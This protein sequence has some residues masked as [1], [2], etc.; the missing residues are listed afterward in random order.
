MR[1]LSD[2]LTVWTTTRAAGITSYLLLYASTV[3]GLLV[4]SKMASKRAKAAILGVHQWSGWFGFLFGAM[5][6]MVLLFDRYVGYSAFE[7]AVPFAS[8]D[9]RYLN[10]IGTLTLYISGLLILSSDLMK[11]LGKRVWRAIHFLAFAGY[12]LALLHGLLLG[13]DSRQGWMLAMYAS[14]AASVLLLV[15]VRIYGARRKSPSPGYIPPSGGAKPIP[16][17]GERR[18][19]R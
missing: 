5:H 19:V 17:A 13:T 9:H 7:L 8:N 11:K 15:A 6:G 18:I 1:T 4:S 3:A 10:G 2:L 16:L 14:T 12:G